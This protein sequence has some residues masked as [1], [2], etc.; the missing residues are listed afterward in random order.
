MIVYQKLQKP[1]LLFFG[2]T[3]YLLAQVLLRL[4][5]LVYGN[6]RIFFIFEP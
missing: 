4:T 3:K 2:N 5:L 6:S 1:I